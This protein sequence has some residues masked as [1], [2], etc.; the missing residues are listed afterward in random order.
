MT[1]K[2]FER[3]LQENLEK[4]TEN[5]LSFKE[6]L[7]IQDD[8]SYYKTDF[9]KRFNRHLAFLLCFFT[10][11][12]FC[13]VGYR[14]DRI[15]DAEVAAVQIDKESSFI[16]SLN[17]YSEILNIEAANESAK[18]TVQNINFDNMDTKSVIITIIKLINRNEGRAIDPMFLS[19]ICDNEVMRNGFETLVFNA[20]E[21]YNASIM[22]PP[23]IISCYHSSMEE[24]DKARK[25]GMSPQRMKIA[26]EYIKH[27]PE[28]DI[29]DISNENL[30]FL[31][32]EKPISC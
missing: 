19:V 12:L 28:I 13:A 22:F 2:D 6:K 18:R 15:A 8:V 11:T 5:N 30:D 17:R 26:M 10:M 23:E 1:N 29:E 9:I 16:I 20:V 32:I 31:R 27:N 4:L 3:N 24:L 7:N 14:V 25:F 21:D